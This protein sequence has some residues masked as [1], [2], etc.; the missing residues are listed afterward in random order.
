MGTFLFDEII[1]GP[2]KS[3]RLG[4]SLGV[5]LLPLHTKLCN[6]NCIYCECG[7]SGRHHSL[8]SLY[9]RKE[10]A[11]ALE[12][13]LKSMKEERASIDVITYAGNGEP[14]LHP[15]FAGII[16]DSIELRNRFYPKAR[17]AVLSNATLIH[18]KS[19]AEA[20]K[21][22]EMNI[23]KLDSGFEDTIHTINRPLGEFNLASLV[24]NLIQ[25]KGNFILQTL[26]VKGTFNGTYIDNSTDKEVMQ[27]LDIVSK[28]RPSMVMIY[29]IARDTPAPGL[30][31]VPEEKL[32]EI[33]LKVESLG[34]ET[35]VSG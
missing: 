11:A 15:A 29:T 6:F 34:I 22:I 7:W 3:R 9:T 13:K 23:L 17:I 18:K 16:N 2:V 10:I 19:V 28:T 27:W 5:N 1:F 12:A 35:Q 33:A 21:K 25:F 8:P 26:F 20:L 14:T 4:V 24:K 30:E 31:K 32:Q